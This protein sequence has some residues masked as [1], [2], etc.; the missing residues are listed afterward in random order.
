MQQQ[1]GGKQS[2]RDGRVRSH[3]PFG[4]ELEVEKRG[5]RGRSE[6][7]QQRVEAETPITDCV[8]FSFG[9]LPVDEKENQNERANS[10]HPLAP[11]Y[12]GIVRGEVGEE[13]ADESGGEGHIRLIA[14]LGNLAQQAVFE[15]DETKS[16]QTDGDADRLQFVPEQQG[17]NQG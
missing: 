13:N 2:K 1:R 17:N 15:K 8:F 16:G 7:G 5:N 9:K 10:E 11:E 12:S 6:I 14:K 4:L 3:H